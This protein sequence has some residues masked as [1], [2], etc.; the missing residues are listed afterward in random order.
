MPP[1]LRSFAKEILA[2]REM[3]NGGRKLEKDLVEKNQYLKEHRK[4]IKEKTE[5]YLLE[6][7][8]AMTEERI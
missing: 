8:R 5:N 6:I 7:Q 3:Q 2:L 4:T 1:E